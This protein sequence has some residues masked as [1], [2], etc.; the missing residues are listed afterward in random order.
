[1]PSRRRQ[2]PAAMRADRDRRRYRAVD[3][4]PLRTAGVAFVARRELGL[5][6]APCRGDRS[7]SSLVNPRML[8]GANLS[9]LAMDAALLDDRRRRRRC[10]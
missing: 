3:A 4:T 6:L 8:S 9:A 1:M 5:L 10:W 7:R 2:R